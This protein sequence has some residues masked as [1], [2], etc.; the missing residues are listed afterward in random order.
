[1]LTRV[2]VSLCMPAGKMSKGVEVC[3]Y[4]LYHTYCRSFLGYW[5]E[6]VHVS[7]SV[8]LIVLV[9]MSVC[10]RVCMCVRACVCARV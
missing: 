4:V 8:S 6:F 10:V 7:A 3:T 5:L 9:C 2:I 1:M